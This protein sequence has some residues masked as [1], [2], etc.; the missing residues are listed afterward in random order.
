MQGNSETQVAS[1]GKPEAAPGGEGR[2]L[3]CVADGGERVSLG[4]IGIEGHEVY[5]IPHR[6]V[7]AVAHDCPALPYRSND[8][9]AV[10]TWVLAHHRVVD[11]A[12]K[13]WGTVLP[14]GFDAIVRGKDGFGPEQNVKNWL[15]LHYES[16]KSRMEKVRGK[17]EFGVQVFWEPRVIAQ[18]MAETSPE[19]RRL[20]EEIK[21]KPRGLAYMYRQRLE[22]VLKREMESRADQ[23]FRDFYYRIQRYAEDVV[24]EKTK[25]GHQ[26]AQMILNLSC[27]L[28]RD[29]AQGL[30]AELENIHKAEGFSARFTGPWPPYSFVGA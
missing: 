7:C 17:A 15:Q 22:R 24:V 27:L 12:W 26:D 4:R 1:P 6:D 8:E 11:E 16:L 9:D 13:R 10:R 14:L 18:K 23:C 30:G 20:E 21:S 5:T 25:G 28:S 3:Y 19:V 29:K 2:Y